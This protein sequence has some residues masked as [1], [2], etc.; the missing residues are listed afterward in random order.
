M[1]KISI[2][3]ITTIALAAVI[4]ILGGQIALLLKLP[5]Y[6]DTI[7]TIF[8]AAILGPIY[9]I[10]PGFLSGLIMGLTTDIYSLYFAPVQIV[11]G[12][13]A[14]IL[15]HSTLLKK[16]KTPIGVLCIAI[17][18]TLVASFITV[19]LFGGIT[20]SGS[21]VIVVLLRNAG[22]NEVFSV[23]VVQIITDFCDRFLG[24]LI[25]TSFISRLPKELIYRMKGEQ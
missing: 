14:G 19:L 11:T 6:L 2:I 22:F 16:W 18:G 20:S 23:F 10:F 9:G 5:I 7:G 13:M 8:V 24:V 15:F 17:P 12:F 25:V 21:S 3:H 1:K 4:N